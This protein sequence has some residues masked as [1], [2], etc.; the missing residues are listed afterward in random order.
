MSD[1]KTWNEGLADDPY[2]QQVKQ[3][4]A[5]LA[6]YHHHGIDDRDHWA[7]RALYLRQVYSALVAQRQDAAR[8]T[9]P[10]DKAWKHSM[11]A[12]I[13]KLRA[14]YADCGPALALLL[15]G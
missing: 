13:C 11:W 14:A 8:E 2:A 10:G 6:P 4:P 5:R 7:C 1:A 9:I 15:P 12:A 3:K